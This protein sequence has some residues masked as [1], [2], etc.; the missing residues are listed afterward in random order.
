[1][2]I[3]Q[4]NKVFIKHKQVRAVVK[5]ANKVIGLNS[6]TIRSDWSKTFQLRDSSTVKLVGIM[7]RNKI[8][9]RE[10]GVQVPSLFNTG[11]VNEKDRA[12][13][14]WSR[15]QVKTIKSV[16]VSDIWTLD[17]WWKPQ[18]VEKKTSA[19]MLDRWVQGFFHLNFKW[20]ARIP[21]Q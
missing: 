19:E 11:I 14:V 16:T 8:E 12:Q 4:V 13:C 1:M 5:V 15:D 10:W 20:P 17:I 9:Q 18:N 21:S 3:Y 7:I 6:I 2:S